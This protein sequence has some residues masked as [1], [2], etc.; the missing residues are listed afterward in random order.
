MRTNDLSDSADVSPRLVGVIHLPPLPGSPRFASEAQRFEAIVDRAAA[1]ARLLA[2][3]GFDGVIVE[4]F[5]DTPFFRDAVPPETT[6]CM[7]ACA[8]AVRAAV[9]D[10]ALGINVL[11]NDGLAALAVA[12]ATGARFIRVNV[13][14]S[15][16]V[17]DQ[18][19]VEGDAAT[20]FRMRSALRADD[21]AVW[22]DVDVKHSSP[23]GSRTLEAET[24]DLVERAC[25]EHVLVTG[26]GTGA[27]VAMDTLERV[28]AAAGPARVWIGSGA[29]PDSLPTLLRVAYGI[30]VGSAL[31]E[32]GRAGA[33]LDLH[34]VN[35]FAD[36][37][38]SAT[39]RSDAPP[40]DA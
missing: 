6:A 38:R 33:P 9:P 21:V 15:A 3:A 7:T 35:T 16:R 18:G 4:N 20:L 34:R 31:R 17:T 26:D 32:N 13:L 30:V 19:I 39:A 23:L 24:N 37:F 25:V 2:T 40:R 27:R 11:R 28:A 1:E 36:A 22:A 12:V 14:T 29:T 10:L 5:G 8:T